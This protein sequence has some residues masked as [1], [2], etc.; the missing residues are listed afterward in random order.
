MSVFSER[1]FVGLGSNLDE[2]LRQVS[3]AFDELAELDETQLLAVSP[4]YR[5][6]PL[7]PP[8]Q[9]DYINA[10]AMLDTSLAPLVLLDALQAI[11]NNHGRTRDVRWGSRT[12]DLDVLLYGDRIIDL[13]PRLCVPHP[14]MLNRAFVLIPLHDLA[15]DLTVPGH[16][17]LDA[18][19][20]NQSREGLQ[21]VPCT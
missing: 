15:S 3:Q 5:S 17:K 18:L 6:P 2:P 10:V 16:G 1:V 7:G 9:S 11:E 4:C 21:R 12:L 20:E 19:L 14:E 13:S 8:G